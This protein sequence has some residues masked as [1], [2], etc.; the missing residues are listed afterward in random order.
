M[1]QDMEDH[2]LLRGIGRPVRLRAPRIASLREDCQWR[3]RHHYGPALTARTFAPQGLALDIG[4][5]FGSFAIP[6][7]KVCPGWT[8]LAFEPEPESYAALVA[9]AALAPNVIPLPFAVSGEEAQPQD[10]AAVQAL[11]QEVLARRPGAVAELLAQLPLRSFARNLETPGFLQY[12]V[13]PGPGFRVESLPTLSARFLADLG[14]ALLKITAPHTDQRILPA[15][16]TAPLDHILG[17]TWNCLP[18]SEVCAP[19]LPGRR[20]VWLPVAG[21]GLLALRQSPGISP[22]RPGLDVVVAMYNAE[23]YILECLVGILSHAGPDI[24]VLVVDDG[25]T[26]GSVARIREAFGEDPQVVILSK[27][28]GGCASARNYGRLMSDASHIAFVDADDLPDAGLFA[29]TLE[30]ARQ[31]GAEIVQAP[32]HAV[33]EGPEGH[34]LTPSLESINE[35]VTEAFRHD[36]FSAT[37]YLLQS[38][39]LTKGQPTI[40]R[41]VYRRDFL[42]TRNLWFPEHI[43]AF[44]DQIFQLSSLHQV[45][46]VPCIDGVSYGHR[47]HP[48]Q[49]TKQKD[50]RNFYSLEMFRLALKRGLAEGWPD[51]QPM[52]QSYIHTVNWTS[53]N[54]REDLVPAF[55]RGAAELWVLAGKILGEAALAPFPLEDFHNPQ[56][57]EAIRGLTPLLADLP[58]STAFVHLDALQWQVPMVTHPWR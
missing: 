14:P 18:W 6:F 29:W 8:V 11:L 5:G 33:D 39:W 31:T 13:H 46:N 28:N 25:S 44:D 32:Y 26:D 23:D 53:G 22:L 52:L 43:R 50:E 37:C 3:A 49:D 38:E 42:D 27:P 2:V 51:F 36:F 1:S 58:Q 15:L 21:P 17:E 34:V 48:G 24:R 54:L 9:N 35:N 7:A 30:L 19:E 56:I 16:A 20:E 55:V 10:P 45:V 41:R 12:G 40:W 47:Q 4:A 57:A